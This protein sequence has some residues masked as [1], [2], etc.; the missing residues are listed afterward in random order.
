MYR[1]FADKAIMQNDITLVCR[2]KMLSFIDKFETGFV[3]F[4]SQKTFSLILSINIES[5]SSCM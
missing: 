3:D 1:K 4:K 5:L 2:K